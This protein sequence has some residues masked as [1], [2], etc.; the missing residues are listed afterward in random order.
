MCDIVINHRC[1]D[2]RDSAGRWNIFHGGGHKGL[3]DKLNWKGW[4]VVKGSLFADG[5][6][7]H[8]PT[9]EMYDAAPVIDH[10]NEAVREGLTEWMRWLKDE[11]GFSAWR[12]DFV[13]GYGP[14][15]VKGYCDRT[16]PAWA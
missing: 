15:F 1:G 8:G 5:T 14:Q 9:G 11:I 12:F 16:Q 3:G 13:K 4:A 6:C 2:T 10:Q 7:K